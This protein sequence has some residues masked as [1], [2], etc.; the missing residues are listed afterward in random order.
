MNDNLKEVKLIQNLYEA[1]GEKY[2]V[3]QFPNGSI[4][5]RR[6]NC[7]TLFYPCL[8]DILFNDIGLSDYEKENEKIAVAATHEYCLKW[9][10]IM[11]E[12][13]EY[14]DKEHNITVSEVEGAANAFFDGYLAARTG[15]IKIS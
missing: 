8:I 15:V 14:R 11:I 9:F 5:N 3:I 6:W 7:D 13:F 4:A 12:T 2:F 10:Q 1:F